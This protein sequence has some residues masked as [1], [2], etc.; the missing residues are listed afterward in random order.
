MAVAVAVALA[1]AVVLARVAVHRNVTAAAAV[2]GTGVAMRL[3]VT[4]AARRRA[5]RSVGVQDERAEQRR[6]ILAD[7]DLDVTALALWHKERD[8]IAAQA[9]V[10]LP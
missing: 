8:A 5:D 2:G 7:R 10:R 6:S 3:P 4:V 1:V 9:E